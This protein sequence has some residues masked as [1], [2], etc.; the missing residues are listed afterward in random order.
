MYCASGPS[1]LSCAQVVNHV[2]GR[3][4]RPVTTII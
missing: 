1:A 4:V 2:S 3:P